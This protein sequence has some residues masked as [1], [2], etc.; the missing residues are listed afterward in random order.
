MSYLK[1]QQKDYYG[2]TGATGIPGP[3]GHIPE[4]VYAKNPFNTLSQFATLE[5]IFKD[6]FF[7]GFDNQLD[8]WFM[9]R[10]TT[11]AFPPYDVK[12]VDENKYV[13]ELA[14]AGY[15]R[16]ELDI[17]VEKDTLIIKGEN[18]EKDIN[19]QDYVHKGIARR[20]FT[21]SFTL[22]EYMI[23]TSA[24]FDNGMLVINLER[25]IPEEA[26]PKTIKIK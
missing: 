11:S 17:K 15:N 21:Q 1:N 12:R 23:V 10:R 14:V 25:E 5:S 3:V 16:E 8:R 19:P 7:L 20:N 26:K 2:A 4:I 6:P 9:N 22:G 24:S 18:Q 13:I